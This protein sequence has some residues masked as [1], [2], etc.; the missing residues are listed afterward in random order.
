MKPEPQVS[1]RGYGSEISVATAGPRKSSQ[2]EAWFTL[3]ETS[4]AL[5]TST[6]DTSLETHNPRII[7]NASSAHRPRDTRCAGNTRMGSIVATIHE[8]LEPSLSRKLNHFRLE[9]DIRARPDHANCDISVAPHSLPLLEPSR[10]ESRMRAA[11]LGPCPH[12]MRHGSWSCARQRTD[13]ATPIDSH[14]GEMSDASSQT[15]ACTIASQTRL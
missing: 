2:A 4:V 9:F 8:T 5:F 1:F 10:E 7:T 13:G 6:R 11:R 15:Q 14:R 12:C 3:D